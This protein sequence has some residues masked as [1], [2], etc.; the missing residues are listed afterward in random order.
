[1]GFN[2]VKK[3]V[4]GAL[5]AGTY[6]HEVRSDISVKNLLAMGE[7]A[8]DDIIAVVK[9]S[10]GHEHQ[11]S[12]HHREPKVDVNVI[13]SGGWYIKFY[14]IEPDTWFISVHQ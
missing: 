3:Q 2:D 7:V 4:I 14:F 12:P 9:K 13:T 10:G 1:M 11:S 6:L 5:K 8:V